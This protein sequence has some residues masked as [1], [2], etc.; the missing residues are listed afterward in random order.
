MTLQHTNLASGRWKAMSLLEQL[1]NI[2][3]EVDRAFHWKLKN[4]TASCYRSVERALELLD[5]SLESAQE[6]PRLKELARTRETLVDY[7][8]GTNQYQSSEISWRKYFLYFTLALRKN[9]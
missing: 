1:S 9:T 8:Y 6:F 5:L 4:N 2:G 3:S 7:F